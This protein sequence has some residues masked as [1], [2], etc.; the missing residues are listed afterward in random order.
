VTSLSADDW[1]RALAT[2][3]PDLRDV[4]FTPQYHQ[5]HEANG[6][7][8]AWCTAH[9]D[10]DA[11]LLVP[12]LRVP[13]AALPGRFDLQTCNGYGGPLLHGPGDE[14]PREAAWSAWRDE[15]AASGIVAALFRLHPLVCNHGALPRDARVIDDR[16]TVYIPLSG[17][18]ADAWQ[19]ADSR[20]RN[21]V[22]RA[23]RDG[24]AV[25]WN[26]GG[27]D[28]FERLYG[29]AMA[30]LQ[31][32]PA[33]RFGPRYF[34]GLRSWDSCELATLSDAGGIVAASVFLWGSRHGH[35]H[36]SARRGDAPNY[37]L[38]FILQ[39]GLERARERG[40]AGLHLGGGTTSAPDNPLLRFKRSLGGN[41]LPYR[42]A[43]VIADPAAFAELTDAWRR[44]AGHDPGWLLG[45]RQPLPARTKEQA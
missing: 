13:I 34:A 43:R 44:E 20:H 3:P 2:L 37:A 24:S 6:D 25:V 26:P 14:A 30:R 17:G 16:M 40:L 1:S 18:L 10:G 32:P 35:Y 21:M 19:N 29:E 8:E 11:L 7:G 39:A 5:L 28:E 41:L 31:A 27:W 23:R 38:N 36:L 12:G 4:Y 9:A 42:V 22:N 15:A 45:Y 33:L